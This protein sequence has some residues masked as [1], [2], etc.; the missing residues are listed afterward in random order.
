[1]PPTGLGLSDT[2]ILP[3]R[4]AIGEHARTAAEPNAPVSCLQG[5]NSRPPA[6]TRRAPRRIAKRR[7]DKAAR[8]QLGRPFCTSVRSAPELRL[9]A[10]IN[11]RAGLSF[12]SYTAISASRLRLRI[13]KILFFQRITLNSE[14]FRKVLL[15]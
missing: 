13:W 5:Q 10:Q 15:A 12:K 1:M 9:A 3:P 11:G 2:N 4:A 8:G 14:S 7:I 6:P